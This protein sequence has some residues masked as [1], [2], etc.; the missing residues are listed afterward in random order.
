MADADSQLVLAFE[1]FIFFNEADGKFYDC[2]LIAKR[3]RC[4]DATFSEIV[5]SKTDLAQCVLAFFFFR[6]CCGVP[7]VVQVRVGAVDVVRTVETLLE[8]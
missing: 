6:F 5:Y 1:N 3:T 7:H 8:Q 2:C 4:A